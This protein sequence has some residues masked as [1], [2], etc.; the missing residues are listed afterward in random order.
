LLVNKEPEHNLFVN[1]FNKEETLNLI[2]NGSSV[3]SGQ[4]FARDNQNDGALKGMAVLNIN[5]KQFAKA[6]T[7]VILIPYTEFFKEW[8]KLNE[9]SRKKGKAIPLPQEATECIKVA[10]VYDNQ[11]HFE[12]VNLM[13]GDYLVYTEFGYVHTGKKTEVTGYTDTYINGMFHGSRANTE[14]YGYSTNASAS[15]KKIV[16]IKKDGDKEFVKLKKTL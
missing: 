3:I 2:K 10:P 6:G 1:K 5:K 14:T 12:F 9:T 8:I 11:G 4:V 16:T 7:S 13:P 15:A